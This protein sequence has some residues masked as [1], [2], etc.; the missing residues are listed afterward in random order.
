MRYPNARDL[1]SQGMT[2]ENIW[3]IVG[4]PARKKKK[5]NKGYKLHVENNH[6]NEKYRAKLSTTHYFFLDASMYFLRH[7][8]SEENCKRS[9]ANL[10]LFLWD[11][12]EYPQIKANSSQN[13]ILTISQTVYAPEFKSLILKLSGISLSQWNRMSTQNCTAKLV[14]FQEK[15]GK[16]A[17]IFEQWTI[18]NDCMCLKFEFI[19]CLGV[20]SLTKNNPYH[21]INLTALT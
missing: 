6:S 3:K 14:H 13:G 16:S 10:I 12:T 8:C 2:W 1:S 4:S 11:E 5:E 20:I 19:Y 7:E 21:F 15:H 17:I 9:Q 18:T